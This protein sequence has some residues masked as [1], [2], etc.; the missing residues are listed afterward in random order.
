MANRTFLAAAIIA[1]LATLPA[2]GDEPESTWYGNQTLIV[3]GVTLAAAA[4]A[5]SVA[6]PPE[7]QG[8]AKGLGTL[9]GVGYL[10]GGPIVHWA[11]GHPGRGFGSLA[12]RFFIPLVTLAIGVGVA[13]SGHYCFNEIGLP[14]PSNVPPLVGVSLGLVGVAALDAFVL[15]HDDPQRT[16]RTWN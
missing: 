15:A 4:L 9:A 14:P 1:T 7:N 12:L 10:F 3:D 8:T 13:C 16:G 2:L 11:H 5:A 6:G